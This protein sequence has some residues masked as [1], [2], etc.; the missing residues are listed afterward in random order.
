LNGNNIFDR[1][2]LNDF[3]ALGKDFRIEA[4]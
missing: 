4:R 1:K 3:A 2:H